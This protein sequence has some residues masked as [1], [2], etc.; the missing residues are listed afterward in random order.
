[1]KILFITF[2]DIL[3]SLPQRSHHII[4]FLKG[5][6]DLTVVFCRYDDLGILKKKDEMIKYIGIPVKFAS[7]FSPMTLYKSYIEL[8]SE[9]YDVCIAQGP[10]AGITAVELLKA[11][12][13]NFLAYEDIDYFP[14][15]FEYEDVY[16]RTKYMEKYCIENSDVTFSVNQHLV[17][18]REHMTGI[19]PYYIPNG[20]NYEIF[21]NEK[22]IHEGICLIFSGSL[23]HWSGMELPIKALPILRRECG[24]V[25]IEIIGR[26][27]YEPTLRK[28]ARDY[29]VDD[30]VHF[31]G[32]VKY[33]DLPNYFKKADI[34][35]CTLFPTELIKYSFPLKAIEYMAS[36]LP[37]IA[38]DIGDLGDLIKNNECGITIEYNIIDYIEKTIELIN[39]KN[40]MMICGQNG[41]KLAIS[42]DWNEIFKKEMKII[43]E[44]L[45]KGI[46]IN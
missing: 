43:Y 24:N 1:M 3:N 16:N 6:Y 28:L 36:G 17:E 4:E 13:I 26:G 46:K 39:G 22:A 10:W 11:G 37:V 27:K 33:N 25:Y 30:Y 14:A 2:I 29:M 8:D 45:N 40:K 44:K 21:K 20:V 31:N 38:T 18:L 12:K 34:G 7:L 19:T 15:F 5:K 41:R 9:K 23:E 32:I 35:L 42:Y